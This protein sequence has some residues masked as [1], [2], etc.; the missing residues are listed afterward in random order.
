M[1]WFG[2]QTEDIN[3]LPREI[4]FMGERQ[5]RD[6]PG[7]APP[8]QVDL[9]PRTIPLAA[10]FDLANSIC[11]IYTATFSV[12]KTYHVHRTYR[13]LVLFYL[14]TYLLYEYKPQTHF[15]NG[16]IILE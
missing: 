16:K 8:N 2:E 10:I 6:W 15:T 9:R 1:A 4:L 3:F 12:L 7:R 14:G 11:E 5:G 13:V